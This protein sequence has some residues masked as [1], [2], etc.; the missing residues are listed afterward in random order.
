MTRRNGSSVTMGQGAGSLEL[1]HIRHLLA[2]VEHGSLTRA[3][4]EL[5]MSVSA[6]SRSVKVLEETVGAPLL[7]PQGGQV[8]VS[9]LGRLIVARGREVIE[10]ADAVGR[11]IE[12]NPSLQTGRV[13]VGIGAISAETHATEV[14]LHFLEH[15]P[16]VSL[17]LRCGLVEDLAKALR[18]HELDLVV[19]HPTLLRERLDVALDVSDLPLS[20]LVLAGRAGHPL[21]K[22][23]G[24]TLI[25]AFDYLSVAG[26]HPHE[27]LLSYALKLQAHCVK[28]LARER[29][30]PGVLAPLWSLMEPL[31]LEADGMTLMPPSVIAD[32]V[33]QGRLVPMAADQWQING[34]AVMSLASR[35]P[36]PEARLFATRLQEVYTRRV[37]ED[38]RLIAEWFPRP[39]ATPPGP[40]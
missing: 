10:A 6:L 30:W 20:P 28:P 32:A 29:A 14:A 38:H 7:T 19:G 12:S 8:T 13:A 9:D 35:P 37:A 24:F 5:G 39:R 31:L 4:A 16:N 34:L 17:E 1:R 27:G 36:G 25:D 2:V 15:H 33:R 11:H 22:R 40:G 3:A 18:G 23:P 26:V 21:L